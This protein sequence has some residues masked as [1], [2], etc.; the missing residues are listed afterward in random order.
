MVPDRISSF[1]GHSSSL[2]FFFYR[3]AKPSFYPWITQIP[4]IETLKNWNN[5]MLE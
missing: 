4:Q 5:G 1:L 3:P 2:G